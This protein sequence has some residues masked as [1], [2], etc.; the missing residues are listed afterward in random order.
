[1]KA[2]LLAGGFGTRL[3]PLTLNTPKPIVPIFDR[4]FLYQQIER[5]RRLPDIDEIILSLNYQPEAIE[6]VLG[7]GTDMGVPIRYVV[8][9]NPLGTGG[10][11]KYACR[12]VEGTVVVFNGDVLSDTDLQ[13]VVDLHRK[14]RACAT[15]VLTPVQNPASYGLVETDDN[16]NVRR[17]LEKPAPED[18]TCD[19]INAGTYVLETE[20]F[21]RIPDATK[22]SIERQYFPSLVE[23]N[24]TF[25]AYVHR[26]YW[27]DIGTPEKYVQAHRDIMAGRFCA[28]P[29]GDRNTEG[30]LVAPS[31][32]VSA[33]AHLE[34]PCFI[35]DGVQIEDGA[36]VAAHSVIGKDCVI[37][38]NAIVS[39]AILG[40]GVRVDANVRVGPGAVIGDGTIITE[41]SRLST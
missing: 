34:T 5:L 31:A 6:Q 28:Y 26:G 16:D 17:F 11:V 27:L 12:A 13:T 4:P 7:D 32:S 19:T 18:I 38:S 29:F 8:E 37:R 39:G 9:P 36:R 41:H 2:V 20:T 23:G 25:V 24:D 10:A 3:R 1:M 14:R 40:N 35:A 33:T 22:W 21:D 30:P 15:I